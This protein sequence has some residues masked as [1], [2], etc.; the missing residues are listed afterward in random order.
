MFGQPIHCVVSRIIAVSGHLLK[1][2]SDPAS[3]DL[4][5]RL[6]NGVD[7]PLPGLSVKER[8]IKVALE[9]VD[10]DLKPEW[11]RHKLAKS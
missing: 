4:S 3:P 8:K 7:D 1:A 5:G 10:I 2:Q 9:H 6:Q 11:A